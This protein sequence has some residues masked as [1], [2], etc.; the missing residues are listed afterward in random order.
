M[1]LPMRN[2]IIM[3]FDHEAREHENETATFNQ[4]TH[5]D[6]FALQHSLAAISESP[7]LD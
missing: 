7:E 1:V 2:I 5:S 4:L 3:N 6:S